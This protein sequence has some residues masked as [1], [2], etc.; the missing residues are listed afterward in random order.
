MGIFG[1]VS[2]NIHTFIE[3]FA[4]SHYRI[5]LRTITFMLLFTFQ[6]QREIPLFTTKYE[7]ST[8]DNRNATFF[9]SFVFLYLLFH[10]ENN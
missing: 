9:P 2:K 6:S 3:D 5:V 4:T 8:L 7:E 10:G 1:Q